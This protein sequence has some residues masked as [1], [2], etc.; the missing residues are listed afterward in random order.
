MVC[1]LAL[2][3]GGIE[4]RARTETNLPVTVA[5]FPSIQAAL[6]ANPGK[7]LFVPDGEYLLTEPIR[8]HH[9]GSGLYG[10]GTLVQQNSNTPVIEITGAKDVQLRDLTLTR[11]TGSEEARRP[12][13]LA[14]DC[15]NLTIDALRVR[16]NRAPT[17]A[18][19]LRG[20]ARTTVS[21]CFI[22]NYSTIAIDDRTANLRYG[23]AFNCIDGTGI[24][25]SACKDLVLQRNRIIENHLR[26]T[27]EIKERFRLGK[28]TKRN[29]I[30]GTLV[31]QK[32]WEAD[33]VENWHQGSGIAVTSPEQTSFVRILDNHIENAAQGIDIHADNVIVTGNMVVNAF[34]GMK[35]M[36]GSRHVL[37][38]NNQF[39]RVDL[40]AIGLM[41]GASSHPAQPAANGEPGRPANVDAGHIIA[42][43]IITDFGYGD[44]RWI[45]HVPEHNCTPF[46]FDNG[47]DPDD[48]PL[49]D[50]LVTGNLVYDTG[51]DRSQTNGLPQEVARYRWAVFISKE[52]GSPAGLRFSNNLFHPGTEGISNVPLE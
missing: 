36:H 5:D 44:S 35:A 30:K 14:T 51:R 9:S 26:P 29:P 52:P 3:V 6:D 7:M 33:G 47:Q 34:M 45:W 2:L 12:A 39:I 37:I 38:A 43:N 48:P 17:G 40:W 46:R 21:D 41:P 49:R 1:A 18:I 32:A 15:Q 23:F 24:G 20:C 50:I 25:A 31:Q 42:N 11:A 10:F 13:L 28:F 8:I 4:V 27:P 16:D 22:E 19:A